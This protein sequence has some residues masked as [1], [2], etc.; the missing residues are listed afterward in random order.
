MAKAK[1]KAGNKGSHRTKGKTKVQAKAKGKR[2]RPLEKMPVAPLPS[3]PPAAVP[4]SASPARPVSSQEPKINVRITASCKVHYDQT[5]K[6]T[7]KE[8]EA[9]KKSSERAITTGGAL[10]AWLDLADISNADNMEDD[11]EMEVVD[12]S[13]KPATPPDIY[14]QDDGPRTAEAQDDDG[15]DDD[16]EEEEEEDDDRGLSDDRMGFDED[17]DDDY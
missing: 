13:G 5:V 2:S 3:V 10:E 11:F 9:L 4:P 1:P 14:G 15:L 16:E 12:E 6:M 7:R 8:W 17:D